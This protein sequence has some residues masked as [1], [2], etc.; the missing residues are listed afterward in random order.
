MWANHGTAAL[1]ETAVELMD[2]WTCPQAVIDRAGNMN[3][4]MD[5]PAVL[6]SFWSH[7]IS[8][9]LLQ[10]NTT[11]LCVIVDFSCCC[12]SIDFGFVKQQ[13]MEENEHHNWV[14]DDVHKQLL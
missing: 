1:Q 10:F 13:G 14:Q 8:Y 2:D 12:S 7:F 9:K 11:A 4:H 3:I 6:T 5:A